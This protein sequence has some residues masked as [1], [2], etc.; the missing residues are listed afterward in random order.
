MAV[1]DRAAR[2]PGRGAY[3]CRANMDGDVPTPDC[4]ALATKRRAVARA[5]RASVSLDPK[6]V[7]SM[8]R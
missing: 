6:L 5:L 4:L 1:L 7:E 2:L 8:G 3:L